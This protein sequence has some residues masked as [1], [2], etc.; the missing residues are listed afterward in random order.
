M[1]LFYFRLAAFKVPLPFLIPALAFLIVMFLHPEIDLAV[2]NT[3][4]D[5]ARGGFY[6]GLNLLI[7]VAGHVTSMA[8]ALFVMA[9]FFFYGLGKLRK[10]VYAGLDKKLVAYFGLVLIIGPLLVVTLGFKE[11]WGR[12]RPEDIVNFGGQH[13]FMPFYQPSDACQTDCSF[14]SGHS[15][16][17][18]FFLSLVFATYGLKKSRKVSYALLGAALTFGIAAGF[19]RIIE[20]KHFLTDVTISGFIVAYVS[21]VLFRLMW[22]PVLTAPPTEE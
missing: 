3:F 15:A 8:S 5:A 6:L 12:P 9:C 17:G 19:M 7:D 18:F 10:R 1:R 4:Y 20:G 14:P 2:S 11:F 21:W 16:R 22:P 13:E